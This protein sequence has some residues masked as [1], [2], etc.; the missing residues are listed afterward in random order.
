LELE[1]LYP[2]AI[3]NLG[4]VYATTGRK[5]DAIASFR[6]AIELDPDYEQ[7]HRIWVSSLAVDG[8]LAEAEG[9]LKQ[10]LAIDPEDVIAAQVIDQLQKQ[11]ISHR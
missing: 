11:A 5:Q 2:A 1:P 10:A 9:E 8:A 3:G 4:V 6:R 7:A